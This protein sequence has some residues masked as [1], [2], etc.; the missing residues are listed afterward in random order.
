MNV[1]KTTVCI[2]FCAI[3]MQSCSQSGPVAI[4]YGEDACTFCKMTIMDNRFSCE[5]QTNTGKTFKFDDLF[6]LLKYKSTNYP[7][8]E[9]VADIFIA[10]FHSGNMIPYNSAYF[11]FNPSF[12]SPMSGNIATF[13][14]DD[15]L[16][17]VILEKGGEIC[18]WQQVMQKADL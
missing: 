4:R 18:N 11:L 16:Q 13:Q 15:M 14:S 1:I 2:F 7:D 8:A 3:V 12:R 10:D 5:L 17:N 6:C 9:K